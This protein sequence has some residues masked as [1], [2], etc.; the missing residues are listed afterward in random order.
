MEGAA[1]KG[2]WS[3]WV[4][5]S[6]CTAAS[7]PWWWRPQTWGLRCCWCRR[8]SLHAASWLAAAGEQKRWRDYSKN[9]TM[10]LSDLSFW[11]FMWI[12]I[13]LN[14][15]SLIVAKLLIKMMQMKFFESC[16]HA[17]QSSSS[18]RVAASWHLWFNHK[19]KINKSCEQSFSFLSFVFSPQTLRSRD[20]DFQMHHPAWNLH[21][22]SAYSRNPNPRAM[23]D[24]RSESLHGFYILY[25]CP[26]EK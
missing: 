7:P 26:I 24:L 8:S 18:C 20:S 14:F 6:L 17:E 5:E 19:N 1:E 23:K 10:K 21:R 11:S 3:T 25:C 4:W 9:L 15:Y 13:P 2:A 16:F 12:K 22:V